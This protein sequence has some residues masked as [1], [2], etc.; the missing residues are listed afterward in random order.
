VTRAAR[1]DGFAGGGQLIDAIGS[2]DDEGSLCSERGQRATHQKNATGREYAD[3]LIARAG[4]V[5]QRANQI[6]NR[7]EAKRATQRPQSL[8]GRVI[9]RR[10]EED[11]A[12]LAKALDGQLRAERDGNAEGFE[13]VGSAAKRG[14]RAVAVLGD[15]GSGCRGHES[16]ATGDVESE[17]T[18]AAGADRID[19]LVALGGR[20]GQ[21]RDA[22]AHDIDKAGQ[23]RRLFAAGCQNGQQRRGLNFRHTAGE[24]VF[25]YLGGLFAGQ[26]RTVLCQRFQ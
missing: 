20:E 24:N 22:A 4:R 5:G 12:G 23:L 2:V 25:Q 26:R 19:Q 21:R 14:D 9:K 7:T 6:K 13:H 17:R 18:S 11:E 8:H 15:F 1:H 3:D 16:R 10:E